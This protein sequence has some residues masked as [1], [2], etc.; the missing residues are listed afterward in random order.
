[1]NA[2]QLVWFCKFGAMFAATL[3]ICWATP[4]LFDDIPDFPLI[5]TDRPHVRILNHYFQSPTPAIALA[6]SSL[7]ERLKENYFERRDI[8]N[9]GLG[10]G[11]PLTGLTVLAETTWKRPSII[12]IETNIM[13]R[14]VDQ[15]LVREFH[16]VDRPVVVFAPLRALLALYQRA[17]TAPP[18][19]YQPK[20]CGTIFQVPAAQ[21]LVNHDDTAMV[22]AE[23]EK[24]SLD[25]LIRNDVATLKA[26][27]E[28]LE[29]ERIK[30]YLYELPTLSAIEQTRYVRTMRSALAS[31]FDSRRWLQLDYPAAEMRWDDTIHFDDRSAIILACA[32]ER[33]LNSRSGSQDNSESS[34]DRN[35]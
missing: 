18:P 11:S 20:R 15:K 21:Q 6:G 29:A 25:D 31:S 7:T 19:A 9:I 35:R 13:L 14:G 2:T 26:L 10:G 23:F 22:R 34:T 28:R 8:R 5:N 16:K 24:P 12:A 32:L 17:L 27:V 4:H 30:V 3:A 33:A 1:M